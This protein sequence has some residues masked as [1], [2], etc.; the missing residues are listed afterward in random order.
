MP[1]QRVKRG[2]VVSGLRRR[3]GIGPQPTPAEVLGLSTEDDDSDRLVEQIA[4]ASILAISY[5]RNIKRGKIFR[6]E[7]K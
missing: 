7:T 4:E 6:F 2:Q 1:L 3:L 5:C